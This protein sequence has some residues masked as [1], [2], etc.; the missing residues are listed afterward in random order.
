MPN[1]YR[2]NHYVPQWYQRRF[3]SP[4]D[5]ELYYLN[6]KPDRFADPRGI[7]HED[8]AL[9]RQGPSKCFCERDLY[10]RKI[11]GITSVEIERR[12]FGAVDQRGQAAVEYFSTFTY[13][14]AH[15]GNALNDLLLYMGLQKLRTPK[16]LAW[17]GATVG[18]TKKASILDGMIRLGNLYGAVWAEAVW[19][20]ADAS[21][22]PTKFIVSD[23]PVT[24]YN[25]ECGPRSQWCREFRDPDVRFHGTHTLFPL[26]SE[27]ILIL[28]NLSWVRNPY[29]SAR[30]LRPNPLLARSA[31]FNFT[32]IQVA[33]QLNE[34][35]VR[36]INFI[37]KS[38]AW[39]YVAAG[40][41]DWLYPEQH[42][43]KSNW[44]TYG[45]GYLL[46]PDPRPISWGGTIMWGGGPGGAGAM[47]E[48]GRRPGDPDFEGGPTRARE[49]QTLPWFKGEFAALVGPYRRGRVA[50]PAM[51][52]LE[53]ERDSDDFHQYHLGLRR[54]TWKERKKEREGAGS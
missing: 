14:P 49:Y 13:P 17:L 44:N 38:R 11:E 5:K 52:S 24:V 28:T 9:K 12:L 43:S 47:D 23:H 29:Q 35:E 26:S 6:L 37:I 46:M 22:S 31:M 50:S 27:K 48:Y 16:G 42:V 40:V 18:T 25:R 30:E 8:K 51:T 1:G 33:R 45:S 4:G 53:A 39:R 3:L 36:E 32:D 7:Q 41:E 15:W 34:Q 21:Q 2:N 19:S 54:K 20:I 10:T